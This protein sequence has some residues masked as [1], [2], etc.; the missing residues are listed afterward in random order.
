MFE[1]FLLVDT[2][3]LMNLYYLKMLHQNIINDQQFRINDNAFP[4]LLEDIKYDSDFIS[5]REKQLYETL[6][7]SD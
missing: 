7:T 6:S 1:N 5:K 2:S 3:V 4:F